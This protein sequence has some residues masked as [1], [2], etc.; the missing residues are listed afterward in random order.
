VRQG[1]DYGKTASA[2]SADITTRRE[3]VSSKQQLLNDLY[4][5]YREFLST[6]DGLGEIEF[7]TKWVD[8]R[9]GVREIVAH[10]TGWLGQLGGGL[11]RMGRGERPTPDGVDWTEVDR[12]NAIFAEHA[13]G[14]RQGEV[15]SELEHALRVFK[16]AAQ[17]LPEERFGDGKTAS[18]MV[19]LAGISHFKESAEMVRR[20]RRGEVAKVQAAAAR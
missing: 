15:L 4:E 19:D 12:W 3:Q 13:R 6:V 1:P 20:W 10:H 7:E 5:A 14:K 16:E 9:W 11:E 2:R 8:G 18:R 17:K